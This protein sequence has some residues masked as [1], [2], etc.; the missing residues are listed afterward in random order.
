[1]I[2]DKKFVEKY[3]PNEYEIVDTP[4]FGY[5]VH[6]GKQS[7]GWKPLFQS[8][9]DAYHSVA[10]M[11]EFIAQHS[12]YIHIFDEYGK[13][14]TLDQLEETLINWGEHQKIR[15]MKYIP[16][17]VPDEIFGGKK[18]LVEST[19]DDYDITIPFNHIEYERLDPY[20]ERSRF[21]NEPFYIK[22]KDGYEFHKGDFS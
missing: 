16:D 7:F 1:M 8:H 11:K 12:Q 15:Y 3:F 6:I 19:K 10:E 21:D 20:K 13:E 14:F 4:Y 2:K 22:D 5:E 17:G 9:E 18:Y